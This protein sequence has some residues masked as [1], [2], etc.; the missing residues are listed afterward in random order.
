MEGLIGVYQDWSADELPKRLGTLRVRPGRTGELFDFTFDDDAL[1]EKI[2]SKQALDPDLGIFS[3]SQFPKDGRTM[4]GV[5]KDSSPDRWGETLIRRR[6]DRDKRAGLVPQ[7][8]RL[9][10]SDYLLGVHD[11]FRSGALRYKLSPDGPFLDNHDG[12]AAPPLVR[13]R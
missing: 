10:Q 1:T 13:L 8:A 7:N 4:F 12:S 2:L 9:G 11:A 3:G 6:F 5:F